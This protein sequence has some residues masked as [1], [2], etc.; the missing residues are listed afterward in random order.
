MSSSTKKKHVMAQVLGEFELPKD[1][2]TIVRILGGRGNNLHRAKDA[3]GAEEFLV[4]MPRKF[5]KSV[6]VKR[7][8]FVVV[9]PIEEGDKVKAEIVRVLYKEQIKYYKAEGA[10]PDA[11]VEERKE[12]EREEAGKRDADGA[13]VQESSEEEEESAEDSDSD[14]FVNTNRPN[15]H[16]SES[17]D[18]ETSEEDEEVGGGKEEDT[19]K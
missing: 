4:S 17:E 7:G 6:W 9:Q 5:R 1:D 8:D 2:E 19:S 10:W 14:L 16:Y 11:F 15:V 13:A 12:K 18:E 3:T